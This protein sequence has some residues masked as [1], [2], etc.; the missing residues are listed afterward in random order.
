VTNA[1]GSID[2]VVTQ[3]IYPGGPAVYAEGSWLQTTGFNMAFTVHCER[4]TLEFDFAISAD[5]V[6]ISEPGQPTRSIRFD[7]PDGYGAEIRYF[8]ECVA[9]RRR[10]TIVTA[11]DG[12]TALE[13]CEAEEKSLRTG[14]VVQL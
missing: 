9:R 5:S 14:A 4:A 11:H 10:P 12:M 2:H 1:A 3:Y 8:V 13:I 6:K 7:E